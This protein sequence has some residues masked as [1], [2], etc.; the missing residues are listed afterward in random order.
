MT[1]TTGILNN[2]QTQEAIA[3]AR[4]IANA[5]QLGSINSNTFVYFAALNADSRSFA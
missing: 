4:A 2:T 5:A 1:A 3:Q